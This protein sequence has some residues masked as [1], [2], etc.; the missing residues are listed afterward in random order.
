MSRPW[1]EHTKGR[2]E[3]RAGDDYPDHPVMAMVVNGNLIVEKRL[4]GHQVY[5]CA[6]PLALLLRLD[7]AHQYDLQGVT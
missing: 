5:R 7:N 2:L 1:I 4:N 6:V 3:L